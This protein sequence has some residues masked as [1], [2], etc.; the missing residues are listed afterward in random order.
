M[1][2]LRTFAQDYRYFALALIFKASIT[3]INLR[4]HRHQELG[5][6]ITVLSWFMEHS[7]ASTIQKQYDISK[8][9]LRRWNIKGVLPAI[10]RSSNGKRLYHMPSL[11]KL[12]GEDHAQAKENNRSG[13]IY[14]RVSSSNQKESGDLQRQV[15]DLQNSYPGYYVIKDVGSGLNFKRSGLQDLLERVHKGTVSEVV[16][17][18][19]DRLCRYGL[20]LLEFIFKKAGT[21]LVVLSQEQE[22]TSTKELADDLLA[23]TTVFVY[24]S[25]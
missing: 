25:I 8:A 1:F 9:T 13:I 15:E 23:I 16:V 20:E 5:S 11:R 17:R 19:K 6:E 21:K 22:A 7:A 12:F 10:R 2:A 24:V 18:H 4:K 14:A 3:S